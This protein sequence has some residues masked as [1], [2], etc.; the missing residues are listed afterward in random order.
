V[1]VAVAAPVLAGDEGK[2][3][4]KP[5]QKVKGPNKEMVDNPQYK[6][7]S[8]FKPGSYVVMK[9]TTAAGK[10]SETTT[11]Y[12]LK[13]V[14]PAAVS[15]EIKTAVQAAGQNMEMPPAIQEVQAKITRAQFE[16]QENKRGERE[17]GEETLRI[18]GKELKTQW[19][20]SMFGHNG[21]V[22]KNRVWT[23][24]EIPGRV[25]KMVMSKKG[26]LETKTVTEVVDFKAI[27]E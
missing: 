7:W 18:A 5:E 10:G 25:A 24:D 14:T 21:R 23:C 4:A 17:K 19:V 8:K 9:I 27:T 12:T 15:L 11:T 3:P 13:K 26:R 22:H 16:K 6:H 2:K 1:L 20:Y